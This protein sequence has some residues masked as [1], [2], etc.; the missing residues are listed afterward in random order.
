[1]S[2]PNRNFC[3]LFRPFLCGCSSRDGISISISGKV[4]VRVAA[5]CVGNSLTPVV[6]FPP[7][8]RLLNIVRPT[9]KDLRDMRAVA[10]PLGLFDT[11]QHVRIPLSR[12]NS[13]WS[14]RTW[15]FARSKRGDPNSGR[16]LLR[17]KCQTLISFFSLPHSISSGRKD[18]T[19]PE[20]WGWDSF[21]SRSDE[22]TPTSASPWGVANDTHRD[23]L[24]RDDQVL[25]CRR[26]SSKWSQK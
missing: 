2:K 4:L 3:F 22:C 14:S 15:G 19:K 1:M 6:T 5:T 8:A 12:S 10:N 9:R 25:P 18:E 20:N 17:E 26:L 23:F 11:A 13:G 7:Q 24:P 21:P 16:P